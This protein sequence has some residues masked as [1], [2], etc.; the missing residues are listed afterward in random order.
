MIT[1]FGNM[2]IQPPFRV[3]PTDPFHGSPDDFENKGRISK[4]LEAILT[5]LQKEFFALSDW[6]RKFAPIAENDEIPVAQEFLIERSRK[7][8][9]CYAELE[10]YLNKTPAPY[11]L[12]YALEINAEIDDLFKQKIKKL[13]LSSYGKVD[14]YS[15]TFLFKMAD[16]VPQIDL[17]RMIIHLFQNIPD[18]NWRKIERTIEDF[19]N[20]L[21]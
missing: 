14:D 2:E 8:Y 10:E 17:K 3:N 4:E 12:H 20:I 11:D 5:C 15:F 19:A 7:F 21:L 9:E 18:D 13:S 6:I 1:Y 16:H